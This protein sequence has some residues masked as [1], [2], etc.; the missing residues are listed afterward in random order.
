MFFEKVAQKF[1]AKATETAI[2]TAK[3]S[4]KKTLDDIM[5]LIEIVILGV[6]FAFEMGQR[7][8]EDISSGK[9]APIVINNYIDPGRHE[10]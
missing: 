6:V 10:H 2:E 4:G 5:P 8:K 1:A 7:K 9:N 3:E